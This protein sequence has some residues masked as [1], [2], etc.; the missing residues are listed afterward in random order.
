MLTL[1][2]LIATA[3][4]I[5]MA[6]GFIR[7]M[8]EAYNMTPE[9]QRQWAHDYKENKRLKK[10]RKRHYKRVESDAYIKYP[11]PHNYTKRQEY[12]DKHI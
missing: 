9:E 8:I 12:I 6:Y 5:F 4:F 7:G 3:I 11:G 2:A 10:E 1:L